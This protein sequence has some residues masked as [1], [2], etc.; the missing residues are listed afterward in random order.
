MSRPGS[1]AARRAVIAYA[2]VFC[3]TLTSV[4]HLACETWPE[5]GAGLEKTLSIAAS[6]SEL[7][8]M[9]GDKTKKSSSVTTSLRAAVLARLSFLRFSEESSRLIHGFDNGVPETSVSPAIPIRAPPQT[10]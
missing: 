9:I 10:C 5:A 8:P 4:V 2:L 7:T 3:L 1:R 6:E